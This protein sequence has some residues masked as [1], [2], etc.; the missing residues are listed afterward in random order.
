MKKAEFQKIENYML[1]CM[2]D[3]AHD[4]EHIYRV[5][6]TALKIAKTESAINTDILIAACLLHDVGREAQF[7][8][9]DICHAAEGGIMAERFLK[10]IGWTEKDSRHVKDCI[11]VH[12]YR[13]DNSP[14][15]IEAKILFNSDKL[16]VTGAIGIARTLMY[17]GRVGESIYTIKEGNIDSG[18]DSKSPASFYKEFHFKLARLYEEFYTAEAKNIANKRKEIS[19][20]FFNSLVNEIDE[21]Y[22][23]KDALP[24]I[25]ED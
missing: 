8:N 12:R 23:F 19:Q 18:T 15:T 16:D 5:L 11:S 25:L 20:L 9:P 21:E 7:E 4:P 22:G 3:S 24:Q 14:K 6:Y 10:S 17:K 2:K 1:E 13:S